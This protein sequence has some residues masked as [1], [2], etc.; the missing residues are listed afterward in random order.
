MDTTTRI[1]PAAKNRLR[2]IQEVWRRR[3][4][5]QVS[6]VDLLDAGITYLERHAEAFVDEMGRQPW[7]SERTADFL[8]RLPKVKGGGAWTDE[9][10]DV[11]YGDAAGGTPDAAL[12]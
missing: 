8:A 7:T 3:R 10:D 6:Q 2:R 4:G 9:I 5:R 1:R 11:V 12:R